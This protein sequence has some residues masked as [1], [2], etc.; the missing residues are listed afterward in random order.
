M[1]GVVDAVVGGVSGGHGD[2]G[3]GGGAEGVDGEGCD[4]GGVDSAG[5]AQDDGLEAALAG[6]VAQAEDEG[7]VEG[8]ETS[9]VLDVRCRMVD[10]RCEMLDVGC[11]MWGDGAEVDNQEVFLEVFGLGEGGAFGAEDDGVAVE[12][13]FVVGADLVDVDEGFV[14]GLGLGGEE[15]EAEIV[16]A[17]DERRSRAVDEDVCAGLAE[18]GDGVLVVEAT[19]DQSLVVPK[20]LADGDAELEAVE[21]DDVARRGGGLEVAGL[22]E[23]VVGR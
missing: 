14:E 12:D 7:G 20:V 2:A 4:E 8:R 1:F 22:V 5:E 3:D 23:D 9:A 15:L 16:L 10:V 19:G 11:R 13:E 21:G 17:H 6:V 18:V